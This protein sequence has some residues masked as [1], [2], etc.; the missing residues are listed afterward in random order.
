MSHIDDA[1]LVE[2]KAQGD[3]RGDKIETLLP[4]S[5]IIINDQGN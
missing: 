1:P 5:D 4:E 2:L 3:S